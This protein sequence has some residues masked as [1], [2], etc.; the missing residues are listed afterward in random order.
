MKAEFKTPAGRRRQY[1]KKAYAKRKA[2]ASAKV[3]EKVKAYVKKAIDAEVQDKLDVSSIL[4]VAGGSTTGFVRGYGIN[5]TISNSGITT[6]SV[7]P[8]VPL[9]QDTDKRIGNVIRPKALYVHYTLNATPID[10][11]LVG[12][13]NQ[14][15]GMPFYCAVIF[16]S[17]KDNRTSSSNAGIKDFGSV[18]FS[19]DTIN[20]FLLPF[21]KDLFT[22]HS[23]KKYKMYPSQAIGLFGTTTTTETLN[24]INGHV[25]MVMCRQK[26]KLPAKL[27]FDDNTQQPTN[28][29]IFCAI[30]VFNVDNSTPDRSTT[31]RVK[32]EMNSYLYFQ[33]A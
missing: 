22:I 25:P 7:I 15:N 24:S 1:N 10:T 5:S 2:N 30:G 20:D 28:A 4:S 17:R 11:G 27:V 18:N 33:N 16:Y 31:V 8:P 21:N 3:P 6:V 19:F 14:Q 9:G 29:R 13:I 32:C 23:F 12:A 26:L